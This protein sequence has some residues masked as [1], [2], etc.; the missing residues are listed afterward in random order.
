LSF[1][2]AFS[3]PV[4]FLVI[5]GISVINIVIHLWNKNNLFNYFSSIPQLS[6]LNGVAQELFK[7]DMLKET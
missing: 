5:L 3:N 4:L 1:I 7:I 2:M 6:K